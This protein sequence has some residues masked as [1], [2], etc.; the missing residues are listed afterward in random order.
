MVMK[1][2]IL[3]RDGVINHDSDAYIKTPA[4]WIPIPG[5]LQAIADL[6]KAGWTVAVATNQSGIARGFFDVSALDAIHQTMHRAL[7]KYQA[8]IDYL[9]WCPHG[10]TDHCECRKPK[11][12][13][14]HQIASHF[15]CSLYNVPVIGD[16]KRDLD[17]AVA[18]GAQ[19][20]L[21]QTG[22]EERVIAENEL[23][24]KT[25]VYVD[26]QSAVAALLSVHDVT[27]SLTP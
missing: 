6:K 12:G 19:P 17:A 21:V 27:R 14:Y 7:A 8:E 4:E 11:P 24:A 18:V 22:K 1:L 26:L 25:N 23:P 5:S 15:S 10:P 9:V 20:I 3:D 2:I 13:M 16:N